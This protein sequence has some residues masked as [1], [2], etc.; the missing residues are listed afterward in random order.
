VNVGSLFTG[1]GGFDLGLERAGMRVVWQCEQDEFCRRV[2]ARHWPG[3]PCYPDVRALVADADATSPARFQEK[4]GDAEKEATGL[5]VGVA[6]RSSGVDMPVCVPS[7][8]V[9][10]GGFPCQD[11]S[12]AGKGAGIDGTRSSLWGEYARLVGELRP[13][14][15]IVENVAALLVRGLRRVLGD[16]AALG[17]DAEWDCLPASAFGAPHRR[18]RFWLVAYPNGE[19]EPG[20]PLNE[21]QG[22]GLLVPRGS[23]NE[24]EG[25]TLADAD[26][27]RHGLPKERLR[28]GRDGPIDGGKPGYVADAEV[29]PIGTGLRED[30]P[31]RIGRGR[32][33]DGGGT[34]V[35][36]A[37][38][39]ALQPWRVGGRA[40]QTG[41]PE[42]WAVEPPVGRVAHGVPDRLDQLAAL[43]NALVPQIAE[44]LGRRIIEAEELRAA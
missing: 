36:D 13:R 4:C 10:C 37:D 7:V 14:Y 42:W 28:A 39:C 24:D 34:V 29:E 3:V 9:L 21:E 23:A 44:W 1:I 32:S 17:Y 19:G 27:G 26:I 2:L 33:G 31:R 35:Q 8:D 25:R 18:D 16:L 38:E 11:I 40:A 6:E 20:R 22:R 12:L 30:E 43:G 41:G 15:V 5:R